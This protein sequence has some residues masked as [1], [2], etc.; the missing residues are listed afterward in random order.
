M[1]KLRLLVW[2]TVLA[3]VFNAC[4][5]E[6]NDEPTLTKTDFLTA[7]PWRTTSL[8]VNPRFPADTTGNNF[9]PADIYSIRDACENDDIK[10][11]NKNFSYSFEE[12]ATKCDPNAPTVFETGTWTL[13][14]D[15]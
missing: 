3:F 1:K 2:L 8:T 13:S 6:D 10:K 4:K 12:G 5:K 11:F 15:E 9:L 7:K 14:A